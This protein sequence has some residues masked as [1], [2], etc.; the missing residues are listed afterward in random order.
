MN[1]IQTKT[2]ESAIKMLKA[3]GVQYAIIDDEGT[4]YGDLV[5]RKNSIEK[6]KGKRRPLKYP[7]GALTN[8]IRPVIA[9]L[10]VGDV[11]RVPVLPFDVESVTGGVGSLCSKTWGL[12]NHT[13]CL[14]KDR[15]YVEVLRLG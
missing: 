15:Q 5:V 12:K 7:F 13:A 2:L 10:N 6:P 14:T 9:N 11:G 3:C 8:H 4:Q 1:E